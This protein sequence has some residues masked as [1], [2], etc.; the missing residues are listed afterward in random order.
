MG[1]TNTMSFFNSF[2]QKTKTT[3]N[4]LW[5]WVKNNRAISISVA[6]ATAVALTLAIVLPLALQQKPNQINKNK[7]TQ[8]E[9]FH[10]ESG[11]L[12]PFANMT[13]WTNTQS[14]YSINGVA[15]LAMISADTGVKVF[16][17]G[18]INPDQQKYLEEDGTIRWCWGGYGE[19]SPARSDNFQYNGIEKSIQNLRDSGGEIVVSFGGQAGVSP[20]TCTQNIDALEK[21]YLDVIDT[22][23]LAR[24]DLDIET[25]NQDASHAIA[26]AKAIKRVQDK[27]GLEVSLTIPIMPSGWQEKQLAIIEAYLDAGVELVCINS[28]TMC[29]GAG[30]L[31]GEDYAWASIRALKNANRQLDEILQS[32]G[33]TLSEKD[34]YKKMGATVA[35]G[36]E[37]DAFPIFTTDNMQVVAT[38][39]KEVGLGLLSFWSIN[40]D[41]ELYYNKGI[42][43]AY[44]FIE[45]C[46][47]NF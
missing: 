24:I 39:A 29:Y 36:Y 8:E 28:M 23:S 17:L 42:N 14:N 16:H 43:S 25:T 9:F 6:A 34:L 38:F 10:G 45:V 31:E 3:F 22:Y 13:M 32:H 19:L 7:Q 20:W 5:L 1:K 40:R 47:N 15:D 37:G 18:F 35:I 12:S 26:N 2:W 46:K 41:A 27:T 33:K 44:E 30:L 21:M 4:R 11:L